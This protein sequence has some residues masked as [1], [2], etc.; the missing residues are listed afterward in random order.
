MK[1]TIMMAAVAAA[2]IL[3]GCNKNEMNLPQGKT[4]TATISEQPEICDT[5]VT[6]ENDGNGG[7]VINWDVNDYASINGVTYKATTGG[8]TRTEFVPQ[9]AGN[10]AAENSGSPKWEV[11]YP[12]DI[13][14]TKNSTTTDDP[15][16][17]WDLYL[18]TSQVYEE[19]S[20]NK[21]PMRAVSDDENLS[22]RCLTGI[23]QINLKCKSGRMVIKTIKLQTKDKPLGGPFVVEGDKAVCINTSNT[24]ITLKDEDGITINSEGYTAFNLSAPENEYTSL[25]ITLY[26][27]NNVQTAIN[28]RAGKRIIVERGKITSINLTLGAI[29]QTQDPKTIV[30]TTSDGNVIDNPPV[31]NGYTIESNVY[32]NGIG[33]ITFNKAVLTISDRAFEGKTT[34]TSITFA[35]SVS[36]IG[37]YAFQN[38][39]N[40]KNVK[41]PS[42]LTT[43]GA[44]SFTGCSCLESIVI[45]ESVTAINNNAF[46]NCTSLTS[47]TMPEKAQFTA[48]PQNTFAGCTS[49]ID[50]TIPEG[51]TTIGTKAFQNC[52]I[53]AITL[54]STLTYVTKQVFDGCKNLKDVTVKRYVAGASPEITEIQA[55]DTQ[56]LTF[57]N[58][59]LENIYVPAE[60][61]ALYKAHEG[62]QGKD[63]AWAALIK[64][65]PAE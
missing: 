20:V 25:T 33:V 55:P 46:L 30:Y 3:T 40:L 6:F 35:E 21:M 15:D 32:A 18:G 48:I 19:N 63:G 62:W 54:P 49:L 57:R 7:F 28:L 58:T 24:P 42:S 53:T 4:F 12:Y 36:K 38:C 43:I 27:E 10:V 8:G 52:A 22:F 45:P 17:V 34:L 2:A 13:K 29:E 65:N 23:I 26:D 11:Y 50:V 61:V 41:L 59:A 51:V 44:S 31:P 60:A 56:Y 37:N 5:K 1:R 47:V 64:A 14:N 9:I 16:D 39:T